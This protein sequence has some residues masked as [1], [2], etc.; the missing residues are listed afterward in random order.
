MVIFDSVATGEPPHKDHLARRYLAWAHNRSSRT[1]RPGRIHL[2]RGQMRPVD[3]RVGLPLL[4]GMIRPAVGFG[5]SG[6]RGSSGSPASSA[7]SANAEEL[8]VSEP[9]A[10]CLGSGQSIWNEDSVL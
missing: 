8:K 2:R 10:H 4:H 5:P 6:R 9:I 1:L 3:D 7:I